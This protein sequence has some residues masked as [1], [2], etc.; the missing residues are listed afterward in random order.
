MPDDPMSQAGATGVAAWAGRLG[1]PVAG[2][3]VFAALGASGLDHPARATAGVG[4]FMAILWMTEGLPLPATSLAPIA[5]FPL[6]G[7]RSIREAAAPFAHELIF[8]FMGGFL[9]ALAMEKWGLHRRIAL[10]VMLLAGTRPRALVGSFMGASALLSMWISN[11]ATAV[12][13]LPIAV[14]V[15]ALV[16]ARLAEREPATRAPRRKDE[17][18]RFAVSL[19]LGLAY[20]ASIGGVATIIGTPPNTILVAY[21]SDEFGVRIGFGRWMALGVPF[22]AV[23]LVVTW[24][25]LTYVLHPPGIDRV[26]GGRDLIRGELRALGPMSRGEWSVFVVFMLTAGLWV[27]REPALS[28]GP[29][30]ERLWFLQRLTDPGVAMLAAGLLFAIPVDARRGVFVLD[31]R[32][33]ERLPWGVLLLFGGGLS[34]AGAVSATG[35][36]VWIGGRVAGLGALPVWA[37]VAAVVALVIFL[38]ELTSNTATAATFLPILGGVALGVG[39]DAATLVVPAAIA[40]SCA[41]MMPVATPP[42]AIVFGSGRVRIGQMVRAGVVL[43]LIGIALVTVLA[44]TLGRWLLPAA[45]P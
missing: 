40:A 27:F 41:F 32:T 5:L 25:L 7:V 9:L 24:A 10:R 22:A 8:L 43:N 28:I 35:L 14:S 4:V 36:D 2:L 45:G 11:S 13:M 39:A 34:L 6:F 37:L 16:D 12:M 17:V 3:A 20:G 44:L 18:D 15:I 21:L 31:W 33:A 23:F 38:T 26:P 30:R 42:N 1:A 19:L 29:V